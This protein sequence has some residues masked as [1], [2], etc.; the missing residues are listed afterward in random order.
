ML[1]RAV[2]ACAACD[3]PRPMQLLAVVRRLRHACE[4]AGVFFVSAATGA[5]MGA[6]RAR[7]LGSCTPSQWE[8]AAHQPSELTWPQLAAELVREKLY[9]SHNHEVPYTMR[10]I[11]RSV[12][13]GADGRV[14]AY[15]V[16]SCHLHG[17]QG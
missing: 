6:L 15:V 5:G 12:E 7:L 9:W 3:A 2:C 1:D 17:P 4:F 13:D 8:F 14:H 11:C 10:P 16:R